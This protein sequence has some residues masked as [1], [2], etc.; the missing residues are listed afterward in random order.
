MLELKYSDIMSPNKTEEAVME[1]YKVD[2][3]Q[4]CPR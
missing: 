4:T 1:S 3:E 2:A